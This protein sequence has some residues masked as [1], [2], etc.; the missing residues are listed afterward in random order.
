MKTITELTVK[1]FADGAD[2]AG[3]LE[4]YARPYIKGFTTN[5]TLMRKAGISDYAAFAQDIVQ[6]MPD[7]P[8]S[9][10]VF[11]DEFA[12]MER[13]AQL[14]AAWGNNVSVKIP[15]TNTRREPAYDLIHRLSHAGV[16]LNV[17]AMMTLEQVRE[18][19]A[20]VQ[21]GAPCYVSVFA[22]RIADTGYDPVP[23][24]AAAV[25]L[26]KVAPNTELIWA[27]PRELLNIFQADAIGCHIITVTNDVLKKLALVG[28]DLGDFSL[29]TVKMFYNDASQA[30]FSL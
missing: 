4:M 10:E 14:I 21:G 6:A 12:D 26:L 17:T 23:L 16:K 5:P 8:I 29:D 13:Q 18:V 27:S 24:M 2:K 25:E 3:M 20:A 28:K 1:I 15:V 9:F 22:G 7:R 11:S 19:V 30:G